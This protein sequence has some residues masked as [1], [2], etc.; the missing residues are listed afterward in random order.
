MKLDRDDIVLMAGVRTPFGAFGGS[1]KDLSANDLGVV[2]AKAALDRSGFDPAE[3]DHVI[4]GNA[5]QTS[6]DAIYCA[7]HIGLKAGLSVETPA[8]TVNRLCGSG[9][10]SIIQACRQIVVGD[11]EVV[12]TGGTE[13]MSQAPHTIR[14]A[15][16]GIPLGASKMGDL[17]WESLYD[18]YA[19]FSMAETAENLADKYGLTRAEVDDY[20]YQSQMRTQA[21]RDAGRFVDEIV[22][23]ELVTKKGH[24]EFAADEHP[25]PSTTPEVLAKLP[26][27]FKKDGVV[28]AGNASG[29]VDGAAA[30][31][32]TTRARAEKAGGPV[33]GR[34][35]A[36]GIAGCDPKIMGIG[37][38]PSTRKALAAAGLT[39]DDM[40]LY[41][42]N[43]AF[44]PQTVAV[45]KEL[46]LDHA[47][48]NVNGGAI[49]IGHPLA[50]TG[51]RCTIT[52]LYEMKR[53]GARLGFASACIGGGQGSTI[54]VEAA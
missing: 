4:F 31:I 25:R 17:L 12:L 19:G 11:S 10:E 20:A 32:V 24:Q 42:V 6:G 8:V 33:L 53:R 47:K 27:Y 23:V 35:V 54:V 13:S 2:A 16:W 7:R 18:P 34:V 43:E 22:P 26:P 36:W 49:A 46:G 37:P 30:V 52:L 48:L 50:A 5:L 21:A 15:R 14:G 51:T 29:I 9:F 1:L 41:E 3:L 44:A 45:M 28:T 38:A 39:L 40:E